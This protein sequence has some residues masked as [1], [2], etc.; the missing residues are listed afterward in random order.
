MI[1][2]YFGHTG[3]FSRN[4]TTVHD[5]RLVETFAASE[6][7]LVK[8]CML[9]EYWE[10]LVE[11]YV[12][13]HQ[14]KIGWSRLQLCSVLYL[15]TFLPLPWCGHP[16]ATSVPL[17]HQAFS[18]LLV[19]L[20]IY[21]LCCMI[22]LGYF[23]SVIYAFHYFIFSVLPISFPFYIFIS[24]LTLEKPSILLS[25]HGLWDSVPFYFLVRRYLVSTFMSVIMER[26]KRVYLK[27]CIK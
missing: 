18:F 19:Q 9:L 12:H 10:L 8:E 3:L 5:T 1:C 17:S 2:L 7:L 13:H 16:I 27:E 15:R 21:F 4:R 22:W 20:L 14:W 24:F 23:H 25:V 6:K 26:E 11:G